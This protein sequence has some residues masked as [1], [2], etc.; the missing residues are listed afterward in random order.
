MP[1]FLDIVCSFQLS[2]LKVISF[3]RVFSF[4][5]SFYSVLLNG[6]HKD[7]D[8]VCFNALQSLVSFSFTSGSASLCI[9]Q[10]FFCLRCESSQA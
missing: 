6:I 4:T 2:M 3:D 9:A 7:M 8:I 10:V 5:R 1:I